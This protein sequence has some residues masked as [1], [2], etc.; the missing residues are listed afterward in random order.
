MIP[1]RHLTNQQLDAKFE[2]LFR[3]M[4]TAAVELK[5][6]GRGNESFNETRSKGDPL[7]I[8]YSAA[9]TEFNSCHAERVRRRVLAHR[10]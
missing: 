7:S 4:R 1:I 8:R 5:L 10:P 3:R 6:A 2:E 9:F